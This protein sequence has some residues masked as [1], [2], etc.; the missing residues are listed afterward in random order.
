[1]LPGP[2]GGQCPGLPGLASLPRGQHV[3]GGCSCPLR[4]AGEALRRNHGQLGEAGGLPCL[5]STRP[6]E[7]LG[8]RGKGNPLAPRASSRAGGWLGSLEPGNEGLKGAQRAEQSG[9]LQPGEP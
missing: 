8:H 1:M 4:A 3:L 7:Y 5:G 6:R 9:L 2:Q